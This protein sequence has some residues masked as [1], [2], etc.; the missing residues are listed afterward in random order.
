MRRLAFLLP[1][2]AVL[3]FAAAQPD[4]ALAQAG[5]AFN[6]TGQASLSVTTATARVALPTPPAPTALITNTGA[7]TA[8]LKFGNAA[9]T[10]ATTDTLLGAGCSA[11][12][13]ANGQAFVAAIT[14][15][16][17]ATLKITTG[18]GIPTLTNS[19]CTR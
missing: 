16:S 19:G 3:A 5:N 15:A 18:G 13:G 12:F 1:F 8:Y 2:L 4:L 7:V 9:V 6:P 17:T 14:A 11:A 10:A